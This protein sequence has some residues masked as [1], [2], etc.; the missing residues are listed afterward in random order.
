MYNSASIVTA[1]DVT[2]EWRQRAQREG[3]ARVM[4]ASQPAEYNADTTERTRQVVAE[5]LRTAARELAR[6]LSAV[7]EI[8]CGIGR[9]TPTLAAQAG[10][11]TALDMTPGMLD[12]A[13]TS[14]SELSNVEFELARAEDLP[15]HG[16]NFDVAVS[17]WVLMHVLDEAALA[18]ICRSISHSCRYFVLMEYAQ[19]AIPVSEWSRPRTVDDYLA[20][21]PGAQLVE[22][23][24]LL[25]G[26][27][28]ST[29][30]LIRLPG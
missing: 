13:K 21:M 23:Q 24:E 8:G 10:H 18:E 6:P 15:W 4:R 7:L 22:T 3:L 17:V 11:V 12:E 20:L 26:G 14:C 25:Y 29:A 19:A 28:R 5:Q 27:D 9:L 2:E 16:R 1:G 30:A